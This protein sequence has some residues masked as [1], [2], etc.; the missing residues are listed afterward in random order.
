MIDARTGVV[1]LRAEVLPEN[2]VLLTVIGVSV[3]P[4][5][6]NVSTASCISRSISPGNVRAAAHVV[7]ICVDARRS[8]SDDSTEADGWR[9]AFAMSL[10]FEVMIKL[11]RPPQHRLVRHR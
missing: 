8:S 5:T 6:S 9:Q 7:E 3:Y 2:E 4:C 11:P 10:R 1:R